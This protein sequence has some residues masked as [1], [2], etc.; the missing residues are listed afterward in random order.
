MGLQAKVEYHLG[1]QSHIPKNLSQ[2]TT[3][4]TWPNSQWQRS[5]KEEM[6]CERQALQSCKEGLMGTSRL[7]AR[8]LY[9]LRPWWVYHSSERK[10]LGPLIPFTGTVQ[11]SP[12][13]LQVRINILKLGVRVN[14][15]ELKQLH[16]LQSSAKI[17]ESTSV[18]A[19]RCTPNQ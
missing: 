19:H 10:I 18:Q 9:C 7:L 5:W 1:V 13:C 4:I 6:H 17:Q 15:G 2:S 16:K 14:I 8:M 12:F 11:R 3:V